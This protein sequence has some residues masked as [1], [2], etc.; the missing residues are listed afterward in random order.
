MRVRPAPGC[1]ASQTACPTLHHDP[2]VRA[3]VA[4]DPALGPGFDAGS[5]SEISIPVHVVGAVDNDFLPVDAHAG[6]YGGLHPRMLVHSTVGRRGAL[7]LP[8]RM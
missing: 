8:E 6:R 4:L 2:R 7:R 1:S 3:V 5:L